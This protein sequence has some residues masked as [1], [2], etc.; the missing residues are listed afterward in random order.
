MDDADC[1]CNNLVVLLRALFHRRDD[2]G[3][4]HGSRFVELV[5][6]HLLFMAVPHDFVYRCSGT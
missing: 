2:G 3:Y 1:L 4:H 6:G 5:V